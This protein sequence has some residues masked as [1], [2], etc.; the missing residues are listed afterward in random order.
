M[1]PII[2]W[3]GLREDLQETMV[4]TC[5]YHQ[6]SGFPETFPI[7][8]F[9][10]QWPWAKNTTCYEYD[11]PR[12][13]NGQVDI[14]LRLCKSWTGRYVV[15]MAQALGVAKDLANSTGQRY[16]RYLTLLRNRDGDQFP[17]KWTAQEPS[18]LYDGWLIELLV[19]HKLEDRLTSQRLYFVLGTQD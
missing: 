10:A 7:I 12:D 8:R 9:S 19:G 6:I 2:Q 5:L 1:H 18:R 4:L 17:I 11:G 14:T 15:I 16:W 3:I 13:D